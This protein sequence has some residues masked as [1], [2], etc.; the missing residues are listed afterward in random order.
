VAM[1]VLDDTSV[2]LRLSPR[3]VRDERLRI[4]SDML[5]LTLRD[6]AGMP[7]PQ[8]EDLREAVKRLQRVQAW[9]SEHNYSPRWEGSGQ[10]GQP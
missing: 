7:V 6:A 4:A 10:D 1:R 5:A 8:Q 9:C 3:Q 2:G